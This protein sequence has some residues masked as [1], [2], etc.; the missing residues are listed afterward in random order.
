MKLAPRF[1]GP[2]QI[3]KKVVQVAYQLLQPPGS[4]IHDV[5]HISMLR[6]HHGQVTQPSINL[7][8]VFS[9]S[10]ILFIT[11]ALFY[12]IFVF[13]DRFGEGLKIGLWQL[14]LTTFVFIYLDTLLSV[15]LIICLHETFNFL[16][17]NSAKN[18][19]GNSKGV[20]T[21]DTL[22]WLSWM[23]VNYNSIFLV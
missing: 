17:K 10:T 5:F 15:Y 19:T 13:L 3:V 7:P 14:L 21:L 1:F 16:E 2:Y 11:L 4:L 6:K 22:P 18:L 8:R 12:F 20:W 23:G 9:T